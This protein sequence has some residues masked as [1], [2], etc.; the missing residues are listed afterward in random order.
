MWNSLQVVTRTQDRTQDPEA[1][2]QQR[3]LLYQHATSCS[4]HDSINQGQLERLVITSK[5][6][7][8]L[9]TNKAVW[10]AGEYYDRRIY[11]PIL[12]RDSDMKTDLAMKSGFINSQSLPMVNYHYHYRC[13]ALLIRWTIRRS[14]LWLIFFLKTTAILYQNYI[15]LA[16]SCF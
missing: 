1:V 5:W 2:R 16:L 9:H 3:Y 10:L 12:S 4:I 15:S 8:S 11:I 6:L 14:S 13:K 7:H